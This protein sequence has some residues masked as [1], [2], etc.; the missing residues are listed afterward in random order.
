MPRRTYQVIWA[1]SATK[2]LE[3]IVTY[4]AGDSRASAI[5]VLARLKSKAES[6]EASP[7][8]GRLVPEILEFGLRNWREIVVRP[9]RIIYRIDEGRVLVNAVIDGRRDLQ[10]LLARRLLR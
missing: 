8:R 2:D 4:I 7:F 9:Y 3:E 5:K 6:L 1:E 10:D